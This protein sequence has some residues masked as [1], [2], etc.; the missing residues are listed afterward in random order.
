M[1]NPVVSVVIP[2]YNAEHWLAET[3]QSVLDQTYQEFEVIIVDDG[4]T[5]TTR[6]VVENFK[7]ERILYLYQENQG[8]SSAR[9]S[10]IRAACGRYIALL[11]A[12]DLFKPDKLAQQVARLER[13]PDLG[14]VTCGF[15]LIDDQGN[16]L[17]EEQH[18]L[19][20]PKINLHTLLFWNPLL[21]STLLIRRIWFEK[22]GFFDESLRRYEDWEFSVRLA[23]AGCRMEYVQKSLLSYR[24]HATNMSTAVD[25]VPVATE[26]AVKLMSNLF[27]QADLP[28]DVCLLRN[29]VF[30]NL[31]LDAAARAYNAGV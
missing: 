11:D 6:R 2:A 13:E 22:V 8:L 20:A 12:D 9:N 18:W 15:D 5:D 3:I 28:E 27:E 25:L 19:H 4:S 26:A 14:V 31:Y 30:G 16:W 24:R 21:P 29:K 1:F 10:G 7:D 17:R 23:L